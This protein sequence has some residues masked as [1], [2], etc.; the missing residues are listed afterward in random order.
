MSRPELQAPP[1]IFYNESEAKKYSSNTRIIQ[2]QAEMSE[3]CIELLNIQDD[4]PRFIL[5]IGCGSGLS[6]EVLSESGHHWVGLDISSSMLDIAREREADGDL[7]LHD[8]GTGVCFRPGSFDGAISVSAL[9]WLCNADKK[10]NS[11]YHR[12]NRFFGTLYSSLCRGARAVFQFYPDHPDQITMITTSAMKAG[13]T[14]GIV[15][16]YPHSTKAK[17]YYLCLFTGSSGEYVAPIALGTG[18]DDS[19]QASVSE[20]TRERKR[21]GKKNVKD[22]DWVLRKKELNRKRGKINVPEDSK[23]TARKRRPRF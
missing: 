11:P 20:R 18:E 5:D 2:I 23:Y 1:E 8:M 10:I 16:D 22:K 14:G 13:F 4:S 9:Q 3:R 7:M 15:I 17:K 12:L 19:V 21:K 6:G